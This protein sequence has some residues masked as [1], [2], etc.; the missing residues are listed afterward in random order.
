MSRPKDMFVSAWEPPA[1][2]AAKPKAKACDP[3]HARRKEQELDRFRDAGTI[4]K[5]A[6]TL[7]MARIAAMV[8]EWCRRG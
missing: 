3:E 1:R 6:Y 5:E 8:E 2:R 7:G 4:S